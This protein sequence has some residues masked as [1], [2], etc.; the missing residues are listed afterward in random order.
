MTGA[1]SS[2]V[3]PAAVAASVLDRVT[4]LAPDAGAEVQVSA[5]ETGLTRFAN[6]AIHQNVAETTLV[7]RLRVVRDGR[8]TVATSNRSDVDGLDRLVRS[9]IDAAAV[10]PVD[11][12]FPGLSP[13]APL[14][15]AGNWDEP[16]AA[17][18]PADR[19][20]LVA[21]FVGA[22]AGL[23]AAG[24][25]QTSAERAAYAN[26]AGQRL[27]GRCTAATV[28]GI[29]KLG[30]WDGA[31]TRA[32]VRLGDLS[33]AA[34]GAAAAAAARAAADP[35]DLAPG[36][37]EVVLSPSCVADVLMFLARDGFSGR[38]V[39]EG[40]SFARVGEAQFDRGVNI[41]EDATDTL[42]PSLPFDVEGTPRRRTELVVAGVTSGVL[43]DRRSAAAAGT[44]STGNA[45]P[46]SIMWGPMVS[47][48]RLAPG[49]G[50]TIGDLTAGMRRGL[51]VG[52]FWYT[53]ILD[54]RTTVV[55]GLTRNG[56]WLVENGEIVRPVRNLRFTQSYL[57]A[58]G[59]G[60]VL[61][62]GAELGTTIDRYSGGLYAV[63]PLRLASW[64]F[65]GN[66]AG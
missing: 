54:P 39:N 34:V 15:V 41:A 13:V 24:F 37:Y 14:A 31:G 49:E 21:E 46:G 61:G 29:A 43:H 32:S 10:V 5:V 19:A 2:A 3:E 50:G 60:R 9:T 53:R 18:A 35:G 63:P 65:T 22:A 17:A 36:D 55:T 40:R 44:T 57:D 26:T 52:D 62:V 66:A 58:L 28:D 23:T 4:S 8:W 42:S 1:G 33:G 16:T 56:A 7:V 51:L 11:P 27:T 59:P 45:T 25:V 30:T 20:E 6:S 12:E 48:L 38:R 64:H 47:D